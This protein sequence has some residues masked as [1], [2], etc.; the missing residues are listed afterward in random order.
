[1]GKAQ[2]KLS[3]VPS[4]SLFFDFGTPPQ[5]EYDSAIH[6]EAAFTTFATACAEAGASKCLP[7]QLINKNATGSDVRTLITSTIDV[8]PPPV[9]YRERRLTFGE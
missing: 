6:V 9:L 5:F 8:S 2:C 1:M 4:H 3:L 7:V